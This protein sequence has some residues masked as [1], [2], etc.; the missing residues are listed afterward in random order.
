[1]QKKIYLTNLF[2]VGFSMKKFLKFSTL[3]RFEFFYKNLQHEER[4]QIFFF[5][6]T[7]NKSLT[8]RI[9]IF[10]HKWYSTNNKS[11]KSSIQNDSYTTQFIFYI[12]VYFIL[13]TRK[14]LIYKKN[15]S[16]ARVFK[17]SFYSNL[18]RFL[19]KGSEV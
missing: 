5:F 3:V 11:N 17:R 10:F 16:F 4:P 7:F 1:M 14:I 15:M 8:T 6:A 13:L 9:L 19:G 18:Q 2:C 12:K